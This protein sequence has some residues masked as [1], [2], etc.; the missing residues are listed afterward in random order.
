LRSSANRSAQAGFTAALKIIAP[1]LL[2]VFLAV[3]LAISPVDAQAAQAGKPKLIVLLIID[4]FAYDYLS[5][6]QDKFGPGGFAYLLEQGANF[7]NCAYQHG[8]T[9]TACGHAIV[10]TGSYPWANGIIGNEWYDRRKGK[11]VEA[12]AED[13]LQ[14]VGAPG[15]AGGIRNLVGTTIGD[16]MRLAANGRNKV[17]TL[18]L[19]DRA[20]LF[21]GGRLATGSYWWDTKSGNFV[22]SSQWGKQLPDWMNSF[23]SQ[24]IAD[25]YFGKSWQRLLP[26]TQYGASTRD[27]YPYERSITGDGRLFPHVINGGAGGP[28]EAFYRAFSL[29]PWAN[30]MLADLAC[31]A[32]DQEALGAHS[33]TDL[34]GISFSST[35][36]VGHAFGP[37][38]QEAE[39]LILRLDQT[40][41]GL[42]QYLDKRVGLNNCLIAMSADHGVCPLPE[43]L[44]ERGL[45]AGRVDPKAF[46]NL[47]NATLSSRLGQQEDWV[48][49]FDPPNLY[50]NLNAIDK[51]KYR[52]PDVEALTAKVARSIPGIGDAFTAFQFF[53]N[54]LPSSPLTDAARKSYYGARSGEVLL[55]PK[56]GFIFSGEQGGTTHGSPYAYDTH[57][58]LILCGSVI[59]AGNYGQKCSPADIAP[60]VAAVLGIQ[61][62]SLS[63]GRV[64]QEAIGQIA[65]P[66]RPST[67]AIK[68][69]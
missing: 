29:T 59:Q 64:L 7:S 67:L 33:Q 51:Q 57:V 26:E 9:E 54:Q 24:H 8:S 50:L 55:F 12:V 2:L 19:K 61:P 5:R 38:S 11:F 43:M 41:A 58:P 4:Q 39:D 69:K 62:P 1:R 18:S 10:S 46:R 31:Q 42:F 34:L 27:D 65:G 17:V 21:L 48:E 15:P 49:A 56:P 20:A 44:K 23:N 37:Y 36:Y 22:T 30:Q 13:G 47:L 14:L 52:Q 63:E 60:T 16:E 68:S 6:Y 25:Q 35:D 32:I 3:L 53:T 45:D 66:P 40:L 28:S